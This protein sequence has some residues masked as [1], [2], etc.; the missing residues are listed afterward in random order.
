MQRLFL[1]V[2]AFALL[3][4]IVLIVYWIN[5]GRV[6]PSFGIIGIFFIFGE[7]FVLRQLHSNFT[8][9]V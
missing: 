8:E 9:S 4:P 1:T 6:P 3:I 2:A 5:E 7:A